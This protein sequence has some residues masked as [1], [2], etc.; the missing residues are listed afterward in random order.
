MYMERDLHQYILKNDP[1]V[2]DCASAVT[3]SKGRPLWYFLSFLS[4]INC[5]SVN[6]NIDVNSIYNRNSVLALLTKLLDF[7]QKTEKACLI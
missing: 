1:A 6:Q 5:R 7:F 3:S 2:G 4:L